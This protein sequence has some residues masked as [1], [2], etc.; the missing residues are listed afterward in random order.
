MNIVILG[1][2]LAGLSAAYHLEKMGVNST[3]IEKNSY[4]GGL[5]STYRGTDFTFDKTLHVLYTKNQY[6]KNLIYGMLKD[7][8][9]THERNSKVYMEGDLLP[10]PFQSYF[11]MSKNKTLVNECKLGLET[12]PHS[13]S[14][15]SN[16]EDYIYNHFGRGIA[17]YFMIPYNTKNWTLHPKNLSSTWA[18]RFVPTPHSSEILNMLSRYKKDKSL[19]I[20]KYGY[21]P[22]FIYFK[23]GGIQTIAES[24]YKHLKHTETIFCSEA[25]AIN[26]KK[27]EINLNKQGKLPY[28]IL[29]ST[30]PLPTLVKET[31]SIPTNIKTAN[32]KLCFTSIYNIN[33]GL[34]KQLPKNIHWI[35]FPDPNTSFHRIGFPSNLSP[36]MAPKNCSSISIEVSYSKYKPIDFKKIYNK[37]IRDLIKVGLL[38]TKEDIIF[39]VLFNIKYA[40][41][42]P[43]SNYL[44]SR[45]T[46]MD[47]YAE[48]NVLPIGRFGAWQYSSMEDAIMDGKDLAIQLANNS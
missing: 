40:Y 13:N 43:D 47:Y 21:N 1:A 4:L 36:N 48:N 45:R 5:S 42:I 8:I 11:F 46:I 19:K 27:R 29:I 32:N 44:S 37:T 38:D 33:I 3:I 18:N 10:Y 39:K 6:L 17:K 35:Y 26:L 25:K 28:D 30:I 20:T 9:I 31:K 12:L 2:G 41:V 23:H 14:P 15:V 34:N 22:E 7:D 16:F 24:L